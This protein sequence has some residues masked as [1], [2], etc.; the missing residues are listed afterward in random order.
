MSAR[1]AIFNRLRQKSRKVDR[2][3]R[4]QSQRRFEGLADRFTTWLEL[5]KGE[6]RRVADL[7]AAWREISVI[8]IG[9]S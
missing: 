5:A 4:W 2:P 8:L 3:A 6:V 9:C 7:E 1:E